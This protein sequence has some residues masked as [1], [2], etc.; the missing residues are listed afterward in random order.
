MPADKTSQTRPAGGERVFIRTL[1][2][3]KNTADSRQMAVSLEQAG[4]NICHEPEEA[5]FILINSCT[6]IQAANQETIDTILEAASLKEAARDRRL[7]VA[8]CFAQRYGSVIREELPEVDLAFGTGRYEMAGQIFREHFGFP[9]REETKNGEARQP[10]SAGNPNMARKDTGLNPVTAAAGAGRGSVVDYIKIAD[11]CNRG[12][13]F[14]IIPSIRGKFRE[15]SVEEIV[16]EASA[17]WEGDTR[18]IGLVSQ[19]SNRH[20]GILELLPALNQLAG[21][22]EEPRWLRLHY[23]Y[24]DGRT[25]DIIR[26]MGEFPALTPYLD[27]PV[28]HVSAPILKKMG[29]AGNRE[30]YQALMDEFRRA[31]PE[32]EIRTS[33][34]LGYPGEEDSDVEELAEFVRETRV[35]KLALFAFSPQEGTPG[36]KWNPY[37]DEDTIAGRINYLREVHNEILAEIRPEQL[38]REYDVLLTHF[39]DDAWIGHRAQDA[40]E[41]DETVRLET[42][43]PGTPAREKFDGLAAGQVARVVVHDYFETEFTGELA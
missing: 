4:Y 32:G 36:E 2:C 19:D 43:P 1:G 5:D 6:F 14:C 30:S 22:F 35:E 23:L 20:G 10:W 13:T 18:E 31:R 34:I 9:A 42:P 11:G 29:R 24:P 38:G 16:A 39:E 40:P 28:Q 8:G 3:P 41:I 27:M 25:R 37:P 15:R 26:Q 21:R 12:C 33:F 17:L 7:V